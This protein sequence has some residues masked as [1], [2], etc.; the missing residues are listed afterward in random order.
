MATLERPAERRPSITIALPPTPIRNSLNLP[1]LPPS[2]LVRT[3]RTLVDPTTGDATFVLPS[4]PTHEPEDRVSLRT[5]DSPLL[6]TIEIGYANHG[7][8]SSPRSFRRSSL[9]IQM[10][11]LDNSDP[12]GEAE[13]DEEEEEEMLEELADEP[14]HGKPQRTS[15]TLQQVS[16]E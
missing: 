16:T 6:Q 13:I 7:D 1:P 9:S 4:V 14:Q 11:P 5:P 3:T 12:R 8:V 2:P 10:D 15:T